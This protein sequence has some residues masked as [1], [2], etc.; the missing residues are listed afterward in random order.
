MSMEADSAF[1]EKNLRKEF[2]TKDRMDKANYRIYIGENTF[3]GV[4]EYRKEERKF[5]PVKMFIS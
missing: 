4:Y 2:L 1:E 5:Y 3:M